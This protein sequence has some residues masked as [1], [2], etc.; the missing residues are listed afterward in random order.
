MAG[1][2]RT[3]PPSNVRL[4]IPSYSTINSNNTNNNN[5]SNNDDHQL[6]PTSKNNVDSASIITDEEKQQLRAFRQQHDL[7]V[8]ETA[9]RDKRVLMGR[10]EELSRTI[11]ELQRRSATQSD[12]LESYHRAFG[13]LDDFTSR[14][15]R[16]REEMVVLRDAVRM[17]QDRESDARRE[18]ARLGKVLE[19]IKRGQKHASGESRL[20]DIE[21]RLALAHLQRHEISEEIDDIVEMERTKRER[22]AIL[23]QR[24][25]SLAANGGSGPRGGGGGGESAQI[26]AAE[27]AA[28]APG[29]DGSYLNWQMRGKLADLKR[30]LKQKDEAIE[31]LQKAAD[32]LQAVSKS[33]RFPAIG[34]ANRPCPGCNDFAWKSAF[35]PATG[36]KHLAFDESLNEERQREKEAALRAPVFVPLTEE[37]ITE[38]VQV[39]LEEGAWAMLKEYTSAGIEKGNVLYREKSSGRIVE[40]LRAIVEAQHQSLH[41]E[42]MREYEKLLKD[43]KARREAM[44]LEAAK[45]PIPAL[46]VQPSMKGEVLNLIAALEAKKDENLRLRALLENICSSG[47][48]GARS[49]IAILA[50]ARDELVNDGVDQPAQREGSFS[51]SPPPPPPLPGGDDADDHLVQQQMQNRQASSSSL[52]K[53]SASKN[54]AP[55]GPSKRVFPSAKDKEVS[56][57]SPSHRRR[58][59][60]EDDNNNNNSNSDANNPYEINPNDV[61]ISLHD[62]DDVQTYTKMTRLQRENTALSKRAS[63]LVL[64]LVE[65]DDHINQ[66]RESLNRVSSMESDRY[67]AQLRRENAQLRDRLLQEERRGSN[68]E[69]EVKRLKRFEPRSFH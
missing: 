8:K 12:E 27:L 35:C 26:L 16:V 53:P 58:I 23:L 13:T 36:Q 33:E 54:F 49:D 17:W 20:K 6:D 61:T 18:V 5:S 2:T 34:A 68:L 9:Q 69:E 48:V 24:T 7:S 57:A 60:G 52:A 30:I 10:I 65:R 42:R 62:E 38:R 59:L 14:Q 32:S 66:L 51:G 15:V 50:A 22:H 46:A 3:P 25:A 19:S 47:S 56:N 63:E 44:E 28:V 37:D 21:E 64:A 31:S 4:P 41:D 67:V 11:H 1:L 29:V 39:W 43:E 45:D 55:Y 40:D